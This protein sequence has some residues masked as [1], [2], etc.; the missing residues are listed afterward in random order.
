[1]TPASLQTAL[2]TPFRVGDWLVNP[3]LNR[4]SGVTDSTCQRS[5][6][7]RLMQLLCFLAA[8]QGRVITRDRLT[9]ELWPRVIVND[10]SLTR[11]VSELRKQ[12]RHPDLHD[13]PRCSGLE[14]IPKKGYRLTLPVTGL[15]VAR[16]QQPIIP[17]IMAPATTHPPVARPVQRAMLAAAF[18]LA[19]VLGLG[20]W[21][22]AMINHG[23]LPVSAAGP[24]FDQV[25]GERTAIS[26]ARLSLSS[27]QNGGAVA[28]QNGAPSAMAV[29]PDGSTLAFLRHEYGKSKLYLLEADSD[30]GPVA[31]FSSDDYLYNLQWSPVGNALLFAREPTAIVTTLL[32]SGSRP[33]DLVMLD[34]DTLTPRVLIDQT[35]EAREPP[36]SV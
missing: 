25:I 21:N 17:A 14:T 20:W 23:T 3:E 34:L 16:E 9:T 24:A 29:S 22:S 11:A 6:E 18:S 7:P 26:G 12:L 32:H 33:A 35:P 10:N 31:I 19:L 28:D 30:T 15:P 4:L 27:L 1:M 2:Q 13:N 36:A 8:N 5:L